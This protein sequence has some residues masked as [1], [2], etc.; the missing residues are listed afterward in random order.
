[1]TR[2]LDSIIVEFMELI[3]TKPEVVDFPGMI[4]ILISHSQQNVQLQVFSISRIRSL[5]S[6]SGPSCY[7]TA[8]HLRWD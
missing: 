8:I 5:S 4:N 3:T 6:S 1:M 2:D 7:H